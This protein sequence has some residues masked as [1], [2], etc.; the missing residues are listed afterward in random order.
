[1]LCT[2]HAK[3][4]L[5]VIYTGGKVLKGKFYYPPTT[6]SLR[7]GHKTYVFL[8][9]ATVVVLNEITVCYY[10]WDLRLCLKWS[11]TCCMS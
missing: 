3:T 1:M 10:K 8:L 6:F 2:K 5:R 4:E 7:M 11:E 9:S